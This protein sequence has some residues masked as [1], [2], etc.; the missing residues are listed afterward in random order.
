M[1]KAI[2]WGED[3]TILP[4]P[5]QLA[6]ISKMVAR[7]RAL[8]AT[9]KSLGDKIEAAAKER[10][11]LVTRTIP[12]ALLDV[13]VREIKTAAGDTVVLKSV[14]AG[15]IPAQSTAAR[16]PAVMQLRNKALAWLRKNDLGDIIKTTV[17]VAFGKGEDK[18]A[19]QLAE[20][21]RKRK[22]AAELAEAVHPQTLNKILRERFEAGKPI[23][24]DLFS[25]WTGNL[26][27]IKNGK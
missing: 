12:D 14:V 2:D 25:L 9:L 27:E 4:E 8:D 1:V 22:M 21:L 7:V 15:S 18:Q 10:Q 23:P 26:V 5:A 6:S 20:Q 24:Q 16:D 11:E 17:S 3:D 13:G 19:Q